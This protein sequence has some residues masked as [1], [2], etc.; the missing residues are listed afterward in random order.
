MISSTFFLFYFLLLQANICGANQ[1]INVLPALSS[2]PKQRRNF[3]D[4]SYV[5]NREVR[6]MSVTI[7]IMLDSVFGRTTILSS[8]AIHTKQVAYSFI[9]DFQH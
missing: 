6:H 9:V 4:T 3:A 1:K 8:H 5:N 2:P 7:C